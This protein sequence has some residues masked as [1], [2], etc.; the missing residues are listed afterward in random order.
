MFSIVLLVL[1][2]ANNNNNNGNNKKIYLYIKD[3]NSGNKI[4]SNHLQ[5]TQEG[6]K[7]QIA[8]ERRSGGNF[9]S[10]FIRNFA[11]K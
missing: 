5:S 7:A 10:Q 8:T 3:I 1:R 6:H 4:Q 9:C 2:K 11:F